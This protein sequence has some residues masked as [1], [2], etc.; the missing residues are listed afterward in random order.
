MI[1][2]RITLLALLLGL[3]FHKTFPGLYSVNFNEDEPDYVGN[4][5]LWSDYK[6]F[7]FSAEIWQQPWA[8]DQPHL[9][10][11]LTGIFLEKYYRQDINSLLGAN[12]FNDRLQPGSY[13]IAWARNYTGEVLGTTDFRYRI[14]FTARYLSLFFFITAYLFIFL[15]A[16]KLFGHIGLLISFAFLYFDPQ[17]ISQLIPAT[18]DSLQFL[19]FSLFFWL[20]LSKPSV[21]ALSLVTGLSLSTKLNGIILLFILNYYIFARH[22]KKIVKLFL[23]SNSIVLIIFYILNPYLWLSPVQNILEIFLHRF[24]NNQLFAQTS[25]ALPNHFYLDKAFDYFRHLFS[26]NYATFSLVIS[27]FL[28]LSLIYVYLKKASDIFL[29]SCLILQLMTLQNI[30]VNW[31]RYYL[32]PRI[33]GVLML[34]RLMFIYSRRSYEKT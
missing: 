26:Q 11:F 28:I 13:R 1:K 15:I 29:N 10:H 18:S 27:L 6:N 19:L 4:S 22:S 17:F 3:L 16:E 9:F 14:I 24:Y 20:L 5:F 34:L 12:G 25:A 33:I 31:P 21:L 8:F 30:T 2:I 32:I 7:N 23:Q